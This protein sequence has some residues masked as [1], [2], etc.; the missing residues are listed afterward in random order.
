MWIWYHLARAGMQAADAEADGALADVVTLS[1]QRLGSIREQHGA[2]SSSLERLYGSQAALT[3]V[4]HDAYDRYLS[5]RTESLGSAAEGDEGLAAFQARKD[6]LAQEL[7]VPSVT[8]VQ[9]T[10]LNQGYRSTQTFQ[11]SGTHPRGAYEFLFRDVAQNEATLGESLFSNGA[12]GS[13]IG[14][15]FL[16]AR[17]W[18]EPP[19]SFEAGVRGGAGFIGLG[20]ADYTVSFQQQGAGAGSSTTYVE[21]SDATPPS[22]PVVEL[23][24]GTARPLGDGGAEVWTSVADAPMV[25]W[26]AGD[27]ESG[28]SEYEYA[29][30]AA[31]EDAS[32][33]PWT[34]VGGRSEIRLD[35]VSLSELTPVFVSVRAR[36]GR[37]VWGPVGVSPALRWDPSPPV[38][39]LGAS[40]SASQPVDGAAAATRTVLLPACAVPEP[41]FPLT[42]STRTADGTTTTSRTDTWD[43]SFERGD[44]GGPT[45]GAAPQRVVPRRSFSWP[46]ADDPESGLSAYRWRIDASPPVSLDGAGW[47]TVPGSQASVTVT[48]DPLSYDADELYFT[49]VAENWAGE[50]TE[51]LTFGPFDVPDPTRPTGPVLCAALAPSMDRFAL[52]VTSPAEDPETRV[53]GYEYRVRAVAN[54]SASTVRDWPT[55][56]FDWTDL[57][58]AVATQPLVLTDGQT[59]YVDVRAANGHGLQGDTISTGPVYVDASP[60]PMPTATAVFGSTS[61]S[62]LRLQISGA[63]DPHS[64]F[65]TQHLAM[66]TS[67]GAAN[68]VDWRNVPGAMPGAYTV[69]IPLAAPLTEGSTYW[70]QIRTVNQAGLASSIYSASFTVPTPRAPTAPRTR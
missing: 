20:R 7:A 48:G 57:R 69:D 67:Q 40:V 19:R 58:T 2:L 37:S 31:P 68:V 6:E 41:A 45:A 13:F 44:G 64:G 11:W 65:M 25:R 38:F 24:G 30:G 56:T 43:G 17:G 16:R 32:I 22:A 61:L 10:A 59:Y 70:V 52:E 49:V 53:V 29:V 9:V 28:I 60:P 8:G 15:R 46:S 21:L 36:N 47:S 5:W 4:L 42:V 39:A 35:G 1:E 3:G 62:V 27:P 55:D 51:P 26:T 66:G 33:R 12:V 18:N 14:H 63:A 50:L 54:G 23:V 34:P